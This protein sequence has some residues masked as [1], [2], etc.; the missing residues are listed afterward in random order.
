MRKEGIPKGQKRAYLPKVGGLLAKKK[1]ERT[2]LFLGD[3][4]TPEE[5]RK[6]K[7]STESYWERGQDIESAILVQEI[8]G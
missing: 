6:A 8:I 7:Y 2:I 4:K 1:G 5:Y 3:V